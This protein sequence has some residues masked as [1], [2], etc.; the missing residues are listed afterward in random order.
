MT[1][2]NSIY[3]EDGSFLHQTYRKIVTEASSR[4]ENNKI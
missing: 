1:T 2:L 3:M 4:G